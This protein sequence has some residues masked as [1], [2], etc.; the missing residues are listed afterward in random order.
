MNISYCD[1]VSMSNM[2]LYITNG[3]FDSINHNFEVPVAVDKYKKV[4][5]SATAN[6][7]ETNQTT[8]VNFSFTK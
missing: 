6:H 2:L 7:T 3:K 8:Y 5:K 1:S 4:K